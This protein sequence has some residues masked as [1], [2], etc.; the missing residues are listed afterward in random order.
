MALMACQ[1]CGAKVSTEAKACP[2]CG[3][4]PKKPTSR[5]ALGIAGLVLFGIIYGIAT[6]PEPRVQSPEELAAAAAKEREFQVVASRLRALKAAMK[7]P[8]SFELVE[9]DLADN[10]TLCVKYR[11]TNSFN[12]VTTSIYAVNSTMAS[13]KVADWN[14]HCTGVPL[15][16]FKHARHAI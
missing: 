4:K 2:S 1:E 5:L 16:D 12:A 8:A 14:K 13:D 9:A 6:Q 10:G 15:R 7:N 11:A 3:V